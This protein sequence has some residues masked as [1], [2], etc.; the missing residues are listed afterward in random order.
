[1][2]PEE[3]LDLWVGMDISPA[4]DVARSRLG[5]IANTHFV[6]ADALRPPFRPAT[7]D[8]IIAEGVLHHTPSTRD[9]LLVARELLKPGGELHFYV[10]RRKSPIR[11]YTDDYVRDALAGMS[12]SEAW[13]ALEP[14]TRLGQALA[15]ANAT[16]VV[17]QDVEVLGIPAGEHDV[18]RLVYWHFAKLFWNEDLTFEENH[19]MNFDWYSPRYSHR[20]TE[21]EIREWCRDAGLRITRFHLDQAGF[22]VRAVRS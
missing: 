21:S 11:E 5:Y 17:P 19:H 22:T 4:V 8:T 15:A 9:A 7:F 14:L 1:M 3:P 16:V 20:Q 6:Q 2:S 18:Q 13:V 12:P 10:Y